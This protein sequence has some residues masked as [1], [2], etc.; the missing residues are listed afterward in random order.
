MVLDILLTIHFILLLLISLRVLARHELTSSAR[1]AWLVVLFVLPYIG[2]VVY[3][4][5]GEIHLGREFTR[6]YEQIIDQ[7]HSSN[8]EVLGND[9][10]LIEAVKPEYRAAFAYSANVTG[11]H[12]TLGNRAELMADAAATRKRMIADFEAATDHIHVLYYIWLID[13]MGIDTA[14]ALIRAAK[15]G[16]TCRAMVDGMGSRKMVG[17]KV[18]QEMKDAGVQLS[19]ALP[20]NNIIKV[21]LLSRIDLR[22]HRKITVIDGKI[23]YSGSRNCADPEFRVKPKFAPWVDIM[24][25]VEG[26]VVAQNQMLFAS[27]WLT[28][29][30]DTPLDSFPYYTESHTESNTQCQKNSKHQGFAAQVFADGPTQRHG[31]SP[32]FLG[33]LISQAQNTL[34]ISTPYFVP[35]YSLVSILCATAYRGVEVT[36]I[37]PKN[38]DSLVV[39]AT[40]RSYYWQLLQAGVKIYEYRPGL[41][42]AKT[43]TID[44]EISLIGS[45]NLDLRSFDLNYENNIVFSDKALTADII[46]RQYQYIAD[47]NEVKLEQVKDWPL[48]Y[49]I[50]NNVVATMGPIL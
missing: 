50:W 1:L 32:Q 20:I 44:G 4:M 16:V 47:S 23:G 5:F 10:S 38:N 49:R 30:P 11:F 40:S 33:A 42:H 48:P 24:L 15:R 13:G 26:P 7:L 34:T 28:E 41:L 45:T 18:W 21:L 35:D 6:K 25:R 36:M 39:A 17:S 31:S 19:V 37:F 43:L 2:V 9:A 46:E 3:W 14:Q 29:N 27:D 12:T 8:P 22:N